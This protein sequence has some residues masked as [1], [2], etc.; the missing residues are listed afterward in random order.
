VLSSRTWACASTSW[1]I[2]SSP[3]GCFRSAGIRAQ[4]RADS[5]QEPT[6]L[7]AFTLDDA[8]G[9]ILLT[10]T[11]SGLDQIP[12]S[13]RAKAFAENEEGWTMQMKLIEK[14]LAQNA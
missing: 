7:V 11:E 10:V 1:S 13:R 2:G 6:T 4:S 14:F 8:P 3:S 12:L 5:S 9:G